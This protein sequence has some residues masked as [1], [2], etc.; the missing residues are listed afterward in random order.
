MEDYFFETEI[1]SKEKK[2]L[3]LIIYDIVDNKQR[4][5]FSKELE[6]YGFRIQKSAFEAK[7]TKKQY[8]S[9]LSMIPQY[10]KDNANIRVYRLQGYGDVKS[11]GGN[12]EVYDEEVI[13]I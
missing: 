2:Y 7:L 9:L 11:W 8:N 5:K 6:K 12:K 10:T 1:I 4:T 3:V 13:I